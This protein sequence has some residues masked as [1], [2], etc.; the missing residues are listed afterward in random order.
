[1]KKQVLF[2]L[3]VLLTNTLVAQLKIN[4][5][6]TNNVS[7]VIDDSYNYS[8]WVELYNPSTTTSYNQY[9]YYFT[10]DL[11]QPKKWH[12]PVSKMI[13]PR[14]YCVLWFERSDRS[15]HASFRLKPEG[16]VLYLVN[17]SGQVIDNVMYPAQYRNISYGRVSDGSLEWTYFEQYSSGLT[18][19][20][21]KS[22]TERCAKPVFV[23][24]GGFYNTPIYVT[25]DSPMTGDTIYYTTN[26][27]EPTRSHIRYTPGSVISI[28]RTSIIRARCFSRN[29]LS[30]DIASCTYFIGE[31]NFRLPVVSVVT[32][33]KNLTDNTIGIYVQGTNG[34][35]GNGM[36][37]PANWNQDWDRA[38]NI[39]LYDTTN[40]S[41]INQEVDI[42]IAG[43]WTRMN[44]QKSLILNPTKK[45]GDNKFDYDI[46]K[47]TK[48]GMKYRSIML[49]NSG[50][51]FDHSMMR[52]GYMQ[53]LVMKRMNL[54]CIAYEPA[55]CFMNGVYYGIQNLRERSDEDFVYSNYGYDEED[56]FLVESWEM[57]YDSEF[58]KLTNYVS[59]SDITQKAVYDNVCT[60]MDM[61]NFMDYFLTEIYLRNTDWP[62][63][64]V[65]AWKKKDGGKWR[66]ILYDT[67]F[68]YNIWGNDH[69]H[70]TLIW[71]L[72]EEAGSL[73]ANAPWS[74]LLLRRLVLNETF[75]KR[76]IDKFA[77]QISSTFE[78][79]RANAILDSLAAKIRTEIVYHKNKWGQGRDFNTDISIMK[80]F[81]ANRPTSMMNFIGARFMNNAGTAEI[82]ISSNN[83]KAS[84]KFNAETIQDA[85]INL[86][87]FKNQ[88]YTL[89][90]KSVPGYTFKQWEIPA[91]SNSQM[92]IANGSIWKYW[93]GN[94]M[95]ASNWFSPGYSDSGWKTGIASLGYGGLGHTTVIGYGS[96]AN[97]KYPTAY[98]RKTVNITDLASKD[99]FEISTFVD[100]GAAVYVNGT[101][102][103]RVNMPAGTLTFNTY[104]T[105]YNNGVTGTFT[106]PKNL[107]TE[108]NNV[109]AVEVHQTGASS[110]D[111]FF[112][113]QF[114]CTISEE[115]QVILSP[116]YASTLTGTFNIRAIYEKN[117]GEDPDKDLQVVIN[118]IVASNTIIADEFGDKD[119]YI[120]IFNNSNREVNIAGWYISD[121]PANP[122]LYQIPATN[123]ALT[124]IP[125]KG[126]LVIRADDESSQ[127]VLHASF[128]LSK[129]GE[130]VT[131]SR[132]NY[133]GQLT[134]MDRVTFPYME[135]NMSYSRIPDGSSTWLVTNPTCNLANSN[136]TSTDDIRLTARMYPTLADNYLTIE[137]AQNRLIRVIDLTGKVLMQQTSND[138]KMRLELSNLKPG[139]YILTAGNEKFRFIKK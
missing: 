48:P 51:D 46:F 101:E 72:G 99:N 60:M 5:L 91:G 88:A 109:I 112:N 52:D 92:L 105:T 133:L 126:R 89:E 70:N 6:M 95:P 129:D 50:N 16:G 42:R 20:G 19:N 21:K 69:T 136:Q 110:S 57:D 71:A 81:S 22:A 55:V 33:Q 36:N 79:N 116:V 124:T 62:H 43:G 47:A 120:E 32:E 138:E 127:G 25:L 78:V 98:F 106:V 132:L 119:D 130:T 87:Y 104:S 123:A 107:L 41:R 44:G 117:S 17:E 85:Q 75:R 108:G 13:S 54:D 118:E 38:A 29:K 23:T 9:S 59:N 77:I 86:K 11:T 40:V 53:S 1:M 131:L 82:Q 14:G 137:N 121:T 65:K 27:A 128:K 111:L 2:L 66:W 28:S 24:K 26:G 113:L 3:L 114:T 115:S 8:M 58:K 100:D 80:G 83:P 61:D 94:A 84:Y 73:P 4:E 10:D 7:A 15:G 67:D 68:G 97:N 39:E 63:N 35:T 125:A 45:Y 74:T 135:Q 49:R 12:P 34:I 96:D 30:S 103:G 31:R 93:D 139:V 76:F 122:T 90:A 102:V 18:N 134:E 56:I 37:T 64:N